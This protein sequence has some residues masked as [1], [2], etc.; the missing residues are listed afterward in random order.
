MI[1]RTYLCEDCNRQFEVTCDSGEDGD[2]DCPECSKVLEWI[3]SRLNIKTD[4]SRA[5]DYTQKMIEQ[6]YGLTDLKD[7]NREGDVAYKEPRQ[8]TTHE[9]ET[10]EQSVRE[11][12]RETTANVPVPAQNLTQ[13][14]AAVLK[15]DFWGGQPTGEIRTQTIST[16]QALASAKVGPQGPNPM[17]ILQQGIKGGQIK[18]KSRIIAAW[19]P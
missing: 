9:R 5:V 17:E 14:Q 16:Q 15:G 12:V 18:N 4:R 11:Y 7:G 6:D 13:A 10:I 19:K 1:I 2:P 3:P 8:P